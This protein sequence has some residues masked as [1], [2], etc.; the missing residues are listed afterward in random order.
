MG[1]WNKPLQP[2][3]KR[4]HKPRINRAPDRRRAYQN[5]KRNETSPAQPSHKNEFLMELADKLM[6]QRK[7]LTRENQSISISEII[8]LLEEYKK[9]PDVNNDRLLIS[10]IQYKLEKINGLAGTDGLTGIDQLMDLI[11]LEQERIGAI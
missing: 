10:N 2:E 4:V 9:S 6:A 1:F 3:T 5:E 8:I 7:I 11:I